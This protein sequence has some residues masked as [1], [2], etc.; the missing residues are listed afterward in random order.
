MVTNPSFSNPLANVLADC[1]EA[2][3]RG[4]WTLEQCLSEHPDHWEELQAL[5][6]TAQ[7]LQAAPEVPPSLDF[8]YDARARLLKQLPPRARRSGAGPSQSPLTKLSSSAWERVA[9]AIGASVTPGRGCKLLPLWPRSDFGKVLRRGGAHLDSL[10]SVWQELV[11]SFR[12]RRARL[13]WAAILI[14]VV[15]LFGGGTLTYASTQSLPGEAL[16]PVKLAIEE[17]R[18]AVSLDEAGDVALRMEFATN[19]L[20]EANTLIQQ[21]REGEAAQS[22]QA[23]AAEV[24]SAMET[25]RQVPEP[26]T[27]MLAGQIEQTA[28]KHD[29]ILNGIA[30]DIAAQAPAEAQSALNQALTASVEIRH[31]VSATTT[32]ATVEAVNAAPTESLPTLVPTPTSRPTDAVSAGGTSDPLPEPTTEPPQPTSVDEAPTAVPATSE[33]AAD[34]LQVA[35]PIPT[36]PSTSEPD[37]VSPTQPPTSNA[38][39]TDTAPPP[40]TPPSVMPTLLPTDSP[41]GD[42][43][44]TSAP[45][46]TTTPVETAAPIGTIAS[47]ETIVPTIG[48]IEATAAPTEAASPAPATT[49]LP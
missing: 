24:Q 21:H 44:P 40:E 27:E 47:I 42:P 22:L 29:Q 35:T 8:R 30:A 4:E 37:Q 31:G 48:P 39:P 23:Y 2:L 43:S 5:L 11:R 36:Q 13:Q 3:E 7:H 33:P 49:L 6:T 41:S 25:L 18:L 16:Y 17:V 19:R 15:S 46:E 26:Q 9:R 1:L 38:V 12:I 45:A 10:R 32:P 28:A 20:D 34:P 14:L